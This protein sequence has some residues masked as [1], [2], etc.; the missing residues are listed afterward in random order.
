MPTE[1]LKRALSI[2]QPHSELILT[3]DK[4]REYR[5]RLTHIRGRVYLY[6]GK[7]LDVDVKGITNE[8]A[9][10]LPR[11]AIVG[12]VEIV[13]CHWDKKENSFAWELA[14]PVRYPEPL[15]ARGVPQPGFWW[16]KF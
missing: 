15:V 12:S 10:L 9:A 6:A 3:G 11:S 4:T 8:R 1:T 14:D 2:R 7:K 13:G 5:R 16:P